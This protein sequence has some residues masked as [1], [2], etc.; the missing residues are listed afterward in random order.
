MSLVAT[1]PGAG[2]R[3]PVRL[4]GDRAPHGRRRRGR[5]RPPARPDRWPRRAA[6]ARRRAARGRPRAARAPRRCWP[7]RSRRAPRKRDSAGYALALEGLG[8]ELSTSVDW[9]AFRVGVS[10]AGRA[11]WP[12]PCSCSPRRPVRPRLDPA[13]VRPGPRRRGDRPADGLG[14]AR[15]ASRRRAARRPVRRRRAV[16]PPAARRSRLGGGGDRRRRGSPSTPRG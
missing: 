2:H 10:G 8:A 11:C 14:P 9:D 6:A 1:P 5:R 3:P 15:P 7:R 16:R 13:D 12:T 4:P